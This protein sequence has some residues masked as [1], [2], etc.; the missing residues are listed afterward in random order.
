[1]GSE[2][3]LARLCELSD[4]ISVESLLTRVVGL[5]EIAR[6]L[7][8]QRE[9]GAGFGGILHLPGMRGRLSLLRPR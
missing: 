2:G 9:F 1:L 3:L 7:H 6:L 4:R 8:P 5:P